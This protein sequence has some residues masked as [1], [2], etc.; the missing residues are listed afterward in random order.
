MKNLVP[1]LVALATVST[2]VAMVA[3][4]TLNHGYAGP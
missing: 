4:F 3:M 1:V 2:L